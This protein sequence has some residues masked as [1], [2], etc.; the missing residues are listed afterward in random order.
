MANQ[1]DDAQHF[2]AEALGNRRKAQMHVPAGG[3]STI[4]GVLY[5]MLWSLLRATKL[6]VSDCSTDS[7]TG[8][9]AKATLTLEPIGGGG[10]IQEY[11]ALSRL[12]DQVKSRPS[13]STWSLREVVEDV[14]PDLYRAVDTG[15]CHSLY[16]FVTEGRM[17]RWDK[18]Y[19]FFRSLR[20]QPYDPRVLSDQDEIFRADRPG[21]DPPWD[22]RSYTEQELF[23][24]IL[25]S[26][27]DRCAVAKSESRERTSSKLWHLLGHFELVDGRT[28]ASLQ[29]QVDRVLLSLIG[30][31]CD[32]EEKR[33]AMLLDLARRATAGDA[34]IPLADFMSDHGLDAVPWTNWTKLCE[35]STDLIQHAIEVRGYDPALDV[36]YDMASEAVLN[37]PS[38]KPILVVSGETGQGK[39]WILYAASYAVLQA[40]QLVVFVEATGD[41]DKAL[42]H[43]AE[44][45]RHIRNT[46]ERLPLGR[47]AARLRKLSCCPQDTPW[48]TLVLD[49]IQDYEEARQVAMAPWAQ[50]GVRIMASCH[51]DIGDWIEEH[52]A[53]ECGRLRVSNFTLAELHSYLGYV[54]G[55]RWTRIPSDVRNTLR[56]PLLASI[57]LD[58]VD[59]RDDWL[60]AREYE[61]YDAVWGRLSAGPQAQ[62]PSD[63]I[64]LK[65]LA[66][67]ILDDAAYPWPIDT[68][69]AAGLDDSAI[70]RL[71]SV[72]WLRGT[73]RGGYGIPHDRLLNWVVAEAM[74]ASYQHG[75]I[76]YTRFL[77]ALRLIHGGARMH[78]GRSLGYVPMDVVWMLACREE[79]NDAIVEDIVEVLQPPASYESGQFYTQ[80][81]STIGPRM[82]APLIA[83]LRKTSDQDSFLVSQILSGI[84]SLKD[85]ELPA[86][87]NALLMEDSH[88]LQRAA[89]R[90]LGKAP[91]GRALDRLW[92]LHTT[93]NDDPEP[94]LSGHEH[95]DIW[96]SNMS[97]I[98]L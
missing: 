70:S 90:L 37:W 79:D 59:G 74:L 62:H 10:D 2:V 96:T 12:V 45:C 28:Q 40:Q 84:T 42:D 50:W 16:R 20:T 7:E 86:Q 31:D 65:R 9:P 97:R 92:Y 46:D 72:G 89:M 14:L 52:A 36:R 4:N 54:T 15:D 61:L 85:A 49:G 64:G 51:T 29:A 73:P 66:M 98:C 35:K 25:T 27:R 76:D 81:V 94:F 33:D 3:P 88:K 11:G 87:A 18:A 58:E 78:S 39:S 6:H 19:R 82:T 8:A 34:V 75:R 26:V 22:Q 68:V 44:D 67:T 23:D 63:M 91:T 48:L 13:G 32:L 53:E 21:E 95:R 47:I 57:F 71:C 1:R 38:N 77:D 60:P 55:D 69:S 17:G 41:F 5:Q 24:A 43:A 80:L 83:R 56:S 93:A 30:R